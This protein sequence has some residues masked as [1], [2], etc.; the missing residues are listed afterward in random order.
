M[1]YYYETVN[2]KKGGTLDASTDEEAVIRLEARCQVFYDSPM[3]VYK[4]DDAGELV[5]VKEW[6]GIPA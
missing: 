6:D 5:I 2:S 3:V 4:E 1:T